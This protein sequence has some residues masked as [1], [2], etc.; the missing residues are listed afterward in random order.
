MVSEFN[1]MNTACNT[2]ND[3]LRTFIYFSFVMVPTRVTRSLPLNY[4]KSSAES[5]AW[6]IP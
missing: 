1:I 3:T 4:D 6:S 5:H 2:I